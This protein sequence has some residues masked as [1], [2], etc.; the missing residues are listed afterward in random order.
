M[1]A[2]PSQVYPPAPNI[3]VSFS[4]RRFLHAKYFQY[5]VDAC[6][7]RARLGQCRPCGAQAAT[8]T[9]SDTYASSWWLSHFLICPPTP[10]PPSWPHSTQVSFSLLTGRGD[11]GSFCGQRKY[12]KCLRCKTDDIKTSV[13]P[14]SL[15]P[16]IHCVY[17]PYYG[18]SKHFSLTNRLSY[19]VPARLSYQRN[20]LV[21]QYRGMS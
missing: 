15:R 13:S 21:K 2:L 18:G 9:Q 3:A 1:L 12:V 11:P 14:P 19:L 10:T 4:Y 20:E 5:A 7:G 16:P 8:T 17:L 6:S